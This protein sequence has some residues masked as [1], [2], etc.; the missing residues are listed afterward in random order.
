MSYLKQFARNKRGKE[1]T[2]VLTARL[3]VSLYDAFQEHCDQLGLTL[4]EAIYLLVE[5]EVEAVQVETRSLPETAETNKDE[6][7]MNT[8]E[9]KENKV[10]AE[11]NTS[12]VKTKPKR[13]QTNTNK[14]G[15]NTKRFVVKPF[16]VD[17]DL[18]CPICDRWYSQANFA[19]HSKE[20]HDVKTEE[21]YNQNMDKVQEM[22]QT[23]RSIRE[24]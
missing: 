21:L 11:T 6:K 23:R 8:S 20:K 15:E 7:M 12:T 3:P 2:K 13:S 18:P 14:A 17:G 5:K 10:S 19:R 1:P 24:K 4:S 22:I 16:V 9:Y